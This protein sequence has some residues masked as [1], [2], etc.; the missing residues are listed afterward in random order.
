MNGQTVVLVTAAYNE[1]R[2]IQQTIDS[3]LAQTVLPAEWIIVSDGSQDGTDDIIRGNIERAPFLRFF[4]MER[5]GAH[6]FGAKVRALHYALGH[7]AVTD[8]DYLGILDA[9]IRFE[10]G[11]FEYLLQA[12]AADPRLGIAGGNIVQITDGVLE[13]RM[14]SLN[15]VAGAVQLFRAECYRS[16]DGFIPMEAGGED[17]AIEIEARMR[18][19]VVRTF[20]E[21][22]VMHYG[23]VGRGAGSRMRARFKYG[24]MCFAL[25][26]HPLFQLVRLVFRISEKPYVLGSMAELAGY[27][28][29]GRNMRKP[30]LKPE[31]VSYLRNEQLGRLNPFRRSGVGMTT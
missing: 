15:S 3:V 18:G 10:A 16:T 1:E 31:A 28:E 8:Y 19:W 30:S 29:A 17:A 4:R 25:G 12:F 11:Y 13:R 6:S 24:R 26:Y 5:E 2:N 9:D 27:L 7:L 22:E 21:L 14:K 23:Y 20:P